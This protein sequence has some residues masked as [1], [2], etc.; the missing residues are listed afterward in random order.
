MEALYSTIFHQPWWLNIVSQGL[1]REVTVSSGGL[2]VGRLPYLPLQG[3]LGIAG[4]G[5]PKLS[6]VL[7][8]SLAPECIGD[9]FP[10]SLKQLTILGELIQQ[11]PPVS[12]TRFR[13]HRGL[14]NTIAFET[15][16]FISSVEYTIEIDPCSPELAWQRLRDKT[17]N[18]IRRA[19]DVLTVLVLSDEDA[20]PGRFC[21]FYEENLRSKHANNN[22]DPD[23][24]NQL[25][26]E[27]LMRS[28]GRILVAVDAAGELQ[29][30]IFTV[31]D[32]H[33]EYY[34]MSTRRPQSA[35]GAVSMLLWEAIQHASQCGL[36]FDMDGLHVK[37]GTVPNLLLTTGFGGS[38]SPRYLVTR[39]SAALQMLQLANRSF[40]SA[41]SRLDL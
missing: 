36:R 7:G 20:A 35:N 9:K 16:G 10:R 1:I 2:V 37:N 23:T 31:W 21:R 39:T 18:V 12:Y 27:C 3:R 17:R 6:H 25:I 11:L 41:R 29:A 24:V 22:Y 5:M 40:R 4:I 13:L 33:S 14:S 19:A 34:F 38:L 30:A 26:R 15:A 8:P 32:H 28:A